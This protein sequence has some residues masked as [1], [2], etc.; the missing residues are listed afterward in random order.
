MTIGKPVNDNL[1]NCTNRSYPY[2]EDGEQP[3][4]TDHIGEDDTGRIFFPGDVGVVRFGELDGLVQYIGGF[5]NIAFKDEVARQLRK[6]FGPPV[7]TRERW[8]NALHI[9]FTELTYSWH[10]KDAEIL[11]MREDSDTCRVLVWT[12]KWKHNRAKIGQW[13]DGTSLSSKPLF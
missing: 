3:C 12:S 9:S 8:E 5:Y 4:V 1:D 10:R 11:L 2:M 7:V 13:V 6:K